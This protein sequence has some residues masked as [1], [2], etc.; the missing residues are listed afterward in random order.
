MSVIDEYRS[1]RGE[2]LLDLL[3]ILVLEIE[4]WIILEALEI[5]WGYVWGRSWVFVLARART[6][7]ELTMT[8]IMA[9]ENHDASKQGG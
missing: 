8:L 3:V 9:I 4:F 7:M 6:M 2:M 1:S 5:F